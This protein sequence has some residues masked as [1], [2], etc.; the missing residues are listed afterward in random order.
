M[1]PA[2]LTAFLAI[3]REGHLT[4]AARRLHL[5][6]PAVSAQLRKLEEDLDTPLFHRTPKGLSLIH[7]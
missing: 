5:T 2:S 4:R 7:I 1:L 6:Q 3:A